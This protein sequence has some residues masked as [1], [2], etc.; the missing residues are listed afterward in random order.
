M[1]E[2][3][4][5]DNSGEDKS[6]GIFSWRE[7]ITQDTAGSAKFYT[8]LLGWT[9]DTMDMGGGN[10]YTMFMNGERPVA[11]MVQPPAEKGDVPTAW[12]NYITVEDIDA[13]VAKAQE[14]GAHLCMPP[15]DIPGRGRFAG[16]AD[17]QGA[18]IAF[19][20]FTK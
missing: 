12:V 19:W 16:V 5:N 10:T 17:P 7:L 15:M 20:E 14:L 1:S 13:T 9:T 18:M 6:P 3:N 11:G 2:E 8:D 4:D